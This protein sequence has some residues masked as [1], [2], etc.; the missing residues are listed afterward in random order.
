MKPGFTRRGLLGGLGILPLIRIAHAQPAYPSR[1][2]RFE[3]PFAAGGAVDVAAR[4]IGKPMATNL[5]QPIIVENRAGANTVIG[6]EYVAHARADGYTLMISGSTTMVLAPLLYKKLPYK[7]SDFAPISLLTK[8]PMVAAVNDRVK[9]TLPEIIEQIRRD[10]NAYTY[11]HTGFGG[12][13]HLL[14]ES[15][16]MKHDLHVASVPYRGFPATAQDM[17]GGSIQMTFESVAAVLP[18]HRAGKVRI[19]AVTS[20]ERLPAMPDVPTFAELGYPDLVLYAWFAMLAPTGT[21]D[22]VIR[23]LAQA[24]AAGS[25][26]PEYR[27][28]VEGTEQQVANGTPEELASLIES[29]TARWR[30]IVQKLNL[31]L[32]LT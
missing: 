2:I 31:Q 14:G 7:P 9:G 26:D 5:G 24:V 23:R 13:G 20:R 1:P 30:P 28:F 10:P 29:D 4:S 15:L 6:A 16:F 25:S 3:V 18:L 27:R 12:I 8:V 32:D 22:H 21:P 11:G 17:M 19:V